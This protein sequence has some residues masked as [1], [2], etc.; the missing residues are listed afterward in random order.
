[1]ACIIKRGKFYYADFNMGG[2]RMRIST[3]TRD[4]RTAY[5]FLEKVLEKAEKANAEKRLAEIVGPADEQKAVNGNLWFYDRWSV[6]NPREKQAIFFFIYKGQC[7]YCQKRV[8]IPTT[9]DSGRMKVRATLDHVIPISGGGEDLPSNIV[10]SCAS[11]NSH[12][13]DANPTPITTYAI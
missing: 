3:K 7:K 12:K 13:L 6:L 11:C 5:K 4:K 10:L 9:R 2:R 8:T 1:M